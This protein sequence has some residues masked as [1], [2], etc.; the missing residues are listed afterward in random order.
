M[1]Y[2]LSFMNVY[3]L[4]ISSLALWVRSSVMISKRFD[5]YHNAFTE[6]SKCGLSAADVVGISSANWSIFTG[7]YS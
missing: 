7:A 4:L 2:L 3:F 5:V 6:H 1:C